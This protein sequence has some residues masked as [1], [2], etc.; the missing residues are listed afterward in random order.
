VAAI[1]DDEDVDVCDARVRDRVVH[2]VQ[3]GVA[4][5]ERGVP[6][7]GAWASS[8]GDQCEMITPCSTMC[9]VSSH[10]LAVTKKTNADNGN[11]A[12]VIRHS[13]M[14]SA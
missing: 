6:N 4:D 1:P 3:D 10:T 11:T 9:Q 13:G 2:E 14:I 7:P 8:V 5:T 12:G